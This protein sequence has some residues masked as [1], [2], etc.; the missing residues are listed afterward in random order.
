M[1]VVSY[2]PPHPPGSIEDF[3]RSYAVGPSA[4]VERI[5][6]GAWPKHDASQLARADKL[7]GKEMAIFAARDNKLE[8]ARERRKLN[9][10]NR[11][12]SLTAQPAFSN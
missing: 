1:S 9:R 12:N 10:I 7:A 6:A 8:Q 3:D 5:S 11:L 2:T 4:A